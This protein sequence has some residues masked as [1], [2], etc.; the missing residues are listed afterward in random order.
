MLKFGTQISHEMSSRS[1]RF[2]TR[3]LKSLRYNSSSLPL[4][5]DGGT[6]GPERGAGGAKRRSA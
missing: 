1:R 3:A 5:D 2:E 4:P 6:E